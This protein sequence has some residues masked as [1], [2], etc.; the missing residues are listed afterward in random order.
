MSS[1]L[2]TVLAGDAEQ[3]DGKIDRHGSFG[4]AARGV[5]AQAIP[6]CSPPSAVDRESSI[7]STCDSFRYDDPEVCARTIDAGANRAVQHAGRRGAGFERPYAC[8]TVR[9]NSLNLGAESA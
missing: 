8:L 6:S 3:E 4:H 1:I 2:R 7:V 5:G 9:E